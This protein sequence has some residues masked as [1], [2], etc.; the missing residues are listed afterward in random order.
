KKKLEL[1]FVP[2]KAPFQQTMKEKN[3]KLFVPRVFIV[4]DCKDLCNEYLSFIR[5]VADIE[6]LPLN[7]SRESLQQNNVLKIIQK[8][9]V[10][11]CLNLF[12][13]IAEVYYVTGES[14]VDVEELLFLEALKKRY[15]E[16]LFLV[17]HIDESAVQQLR[18]Y[19]VKKL[20]CVT[21]EEKKKQDDE[22]VA[23]ESMT[24]KMKDIMGDNAN[25]PFDS[26][27]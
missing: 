3:I 6:D 9:V 5:C 12:G 1:L 17:D 16:I 19:D 18:E 22:K 11:N 23:Y 26:R 15:F 20:V 13:E 7:L 2:K 24:K 4:D 14:R 27:Q 10:K 21:K 25:K 8:N